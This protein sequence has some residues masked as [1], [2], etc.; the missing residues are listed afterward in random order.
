MGWKFEEW[1]LKVVIKL[2]RVISRFLFHFSMAF[3]VMIPVTELD[4]SLHRQY[5]IRLGRNINGT[6]FA[7]VEGTLY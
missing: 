4:I 7:R 6:F 1:F 3:S 5:N 2:K